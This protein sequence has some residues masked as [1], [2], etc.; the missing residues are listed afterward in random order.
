MEY[1]TVPENKNEQLDKENTEQ[2]GQVHWYGSRNE[3][4]ILVTKIN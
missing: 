1:V 2:R 3:G 4:Y